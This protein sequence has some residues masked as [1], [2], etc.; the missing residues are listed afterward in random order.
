M[1][2][3]YD[4]KRFKRFMS[5]HNGIAPVEGKYGPFFIDL[6]AKSTI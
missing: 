3:P 4:S 2:N 1:E 6:K 5:F